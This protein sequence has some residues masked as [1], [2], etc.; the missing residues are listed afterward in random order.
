MSESWH[1]CVSY[2]TGW[3]GILRVMPVTYYKGPSLGKK[4]PCAICAGPGEGPR[5]K[6]TLAYGVEVWLCEMHRSL[7]FQQR[8][9][10]RDFIV[11]LSCVWRAA[12]CLTR[13]R[14]RA[15]DAFRESLR[16]QPDPPLRGS[17]AWPKLREEAELRF[18]AGET[19]ADVI[20][21]LHAKL[22]GTAAQPPSLRTVQRWFHE[23]RWRGSPGDGRGSVGDRR[24]VSGRT[25]NKSRN[26]LDVGRLR[27]HVNRA[28]PLQVV[29][30][31][32]KTS[33]VVGKRRRVTR[34]V[35]EH[36][37]GKLEDP[38]NRSP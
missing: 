37:R 30:T 29:P 19:V 23:G 5:A 4:P 13:Q 8:R 28:D 20:G 21:D 11:S 38:T 1:I 34:D 17:Y 10:G 16:P 14:Q 32:N 12:N 33:R 35:H 31:V 2:D 18:A 3:R 25:Q 36:R 6:L 7:E 22:D 27:K 26:G 15:L 9:V 24:S